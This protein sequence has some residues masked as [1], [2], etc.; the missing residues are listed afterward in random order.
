[1][2]K[3][4]SNIQ[5]QHQSTTLVEHQKMGLN[6]NEALDLKKKFALI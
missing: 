5:K 6:S 2:S 4:N 3:S 1:M